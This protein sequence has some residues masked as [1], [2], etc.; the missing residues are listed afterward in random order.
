LADEEEEGV[1][2]PFREH[3]LLLCALDFGGGP[4][5]DPEGDNDEEARPVNE[6]VV[7]QDAQM[8]QDMIQSLADENDMP[9]DELPLEL[10]EPAA[11]E[12]DREMK[13]QFVDASS[14]NGL[15]APAPAA[16]EAECIFAPNENLP[17]AAIPSAKDVEDTYW[18]LMK[19][20]Y[21]LSPQ[22][23]AK[24][25]G[26]YSVKRGQKWAK[27]QPH[28]EHI[29]KYNFINLAMNPEGFYEQAWMLY[30]PHVWTTDTT[31]PEYHMLKDECGLPEGETWASIALKS[32]LVG[33]DSTALICLKHAATTMGHNKEAIRKLADLLQ[34]QGFMSKEAK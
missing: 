5:S 18:K 3:Q 12:G 20:K 6:D 21:W 24:L 13:D 25:P 28:H 14:L 2:R 31:D 32:G 30:L 23:V 33:K 27:L 29:V 10:R 16:P 4:S 15:P 19:G 9:M 8:K 26:S 34:E 11:P 17:A 1:S 7:M 22:E